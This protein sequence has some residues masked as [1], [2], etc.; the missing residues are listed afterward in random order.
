[1][2][3]D[4]K[5]FSMGLLYIGTVLL[6]GL[7]FFQSFGLWI[8][9]VSAIVLSI[10]IVRKD[11]RCYIMSILFLLPISIYFLLAAAG[12]PRLYA[13]I[14]LIPLLFFIMSLKRDKK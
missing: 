7:L 8:Y 5:K 4:M 2:G 13:F 1:M 14:I 10:G 6:A 11:T 9:L 3:M 12:L